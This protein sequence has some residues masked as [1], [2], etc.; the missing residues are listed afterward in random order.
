MLDLCSVGRLRFKLDSSYNYRSN[1]DLIHRYFPWVF[2]IV[3]CPVP[4][5][6]SIY[7]IWLRICIGG[8]THLM[9]STWERYII[10]FTRAYSAIGNLKSPIN[11]PLG[12]GNW[13][14]ALW[15]VWVSLIFVAKSVDTVTIIWWY[16]Y[17]LVD[18][19]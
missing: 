2:S 14:L 16:F 18:L 6:R 7:P 4:T 15:V 10:L 8:M 19:F 12:K 11:I 1:P 9:L 5:F 13:L 3:M 17:S